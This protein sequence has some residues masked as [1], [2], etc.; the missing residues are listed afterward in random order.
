MWQTVQVSCDEVANIWLSI[1][2]QQITT[3][4]RFRKLHDGAHS[5]AGPVPQANP[6]SDF[7]FELIAAF[8]I[9]SFL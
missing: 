5:R 1:N 6:L 4:R 8:T 3:F 7:E 9:A 2:C